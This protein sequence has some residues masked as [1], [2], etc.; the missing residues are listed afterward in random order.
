MPP[1]DV[2]WEDE[3]IENNGELLGLVFYIQI[4]QLR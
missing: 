1:Q 3:V 4:L 2:I